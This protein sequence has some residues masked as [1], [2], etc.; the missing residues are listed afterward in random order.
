MKGIYLLIFEVKRPKTKNVGGLGTIK[1]DPGTYT[2]VGSAQNG[3]E[4][5]V[6]RHLREDK[7]KHW[8]IDY[9]LESQYIK[10]V[11]A[12]EGGKSEE[13]E[14]A[15]FLKEEL[16]GIEEFGCSDCDCSSHL[17]YT[18]KDPDEVVESVRKFK[19]KEDMGLKEL[20]SQ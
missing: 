14:T 15:S 5:R 11:M 20:E 10:E 19:G 7:R 9:L 13:C 3:I 8:H 17:F 12:Y 1:F 18:E 4:G 16:Q 2:Y 6:K